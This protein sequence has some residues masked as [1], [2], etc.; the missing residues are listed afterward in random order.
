MNN[1]DQQP[2]FIS[3]SNGMRIA[4]KQIQTAPIISAWTWYNVG[5]RNEVPGKTGLSH[6]VEHMQFKGTKNF[7]GKEM[8][9]A[10]ARTGGYSNALTSPD[11]TAYFQTL[12]SAVLETALI[13]EA[14]RMVNSLYDP[15]EVE[16]ERTVI[17]S[18]RE[19][20]END[21]QFLLGEAIQ[22]AAFC[23]H[24][25]RNEVLGST[26]DL[27]SITRDDLYRHYR[28]YYQSGNALLCLAGSFDL[29]EALALIRKHFEPIENTEPRR[30]IP[31]PENEIA[32][33]RQI[34]LQ[35]PEEADY[36]EIAWR[37]PK[38]SDPDFFAYTLIESIL[39]GPSTLN[40]FGSGGIGN[41]SSRLYRELVESQLA[42]SVY[43]SLNASIDPGIY[44]L[45]ITCRG[46][47]PPEEVIER[48]DQVID[49]F[50]NKPASL[51]ERTI[52][53]KQARANFAYSSD[54]ITNQA[55]WLG[56][57]QSFADYS[58]FTDYVKRLEQVSAKDILRVARLYLNPAHRVTGVYRHREATDG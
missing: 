53:L 34:E 36:I 9:D 39:S 48:I 18:E 13:F 5:S 15:Q 52:A 30:S 21:P 29:D 40:M 8:E 57:A 45:N 25:Y 33:A 50:L 58:W 12:P 20:N 46:D 49:Q 2:L 19:G 56:Y 28:N 22:Q 26:E 55:F 11:W 6:W 4:L 17:L 44:T 43:G 31:T 3:L 27:L 10:I 32:S 1:S 24:P 42:A 14:D 35:G 23:Q 7:S 16:T 41:R 37:S 38:A 47:H 54:N 51:E